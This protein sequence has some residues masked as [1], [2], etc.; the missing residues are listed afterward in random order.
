MKI[1]TIMVCVNFGDFLKIT[2][3]FNKKILKDEII[4]VTASFD[5]ETIEYCEENGITY[6]LYD[7]NHALSVESYRDIVY[8]LNMGLEYAYDKYK[9]ENVIF[10]KMDPDVILLN[11]L[12]QL[13]EMVDDDTLLNVARYRID[14]TDKFKA[15]LDVNGEV[16]IE[17]LKN[18]FIDDLE[19]AH[20]YGYFQLY[21]QRRL[22][23]VI[24]QECYM[25]VLFNEGFSN[26]LLLN[27]YSCL[28]LGSSRGENW[29]GRVTEKWEMNK[30]KTNKMEHYYQNI[31]GWFDYQGFYNDIVRRLQPGNK[32]VEVGAWR[33][34]ST[35]YLGVEIINSKKD[36]Q[37]TVVDRWS[38]YEAMGDLYPDPEIIYQQ[39]LENM[40][41][42]EGKM[43]FQHFRMLSVEAAKLF[44]DGSL[45]FVFI[46]GDH[47][48]ESASADMDAWLPKIKR[49]GVIAG[50]DYQPETWDGVVKAV[51]EKI[52]NY[53]I[54]GVVW[55]ATI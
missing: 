43:K 55:Y 13:A 45:D 32:I 50:H 5:K 48:Y 20:G 38:W 46:D 3:P 14:S 31:E 18:D 4:I 23:P 51:Q 37:L 36:V 39:F 15:C 54:N 53:K 47:T 35:A 52:Q 2:Y 17:K 1:I 30:I 33:G 9:D 8:F 6:L 41:P 22:Y 19:V 40:K 25:D 10:L 27:E 28:T 24:D 49:G 29:K 12:E 11:D 42:I 16:N 26:K 34:C 7:E 21:K 44:E